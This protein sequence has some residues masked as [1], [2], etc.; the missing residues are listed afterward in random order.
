MRRWLLTIAGVLLALTVQAADISNPTQFMFVGDRDDDIID[1]ISLADAKLVHRIETSIHAD[2]IIATPFAPILM[3]AN[4]E[5]K[6]AVFYNLEE[7]AEVAKIDLPI[8][9]RHV[10][11]DTTGAKIGIS[12]SVDGGFVL[13]HAYKKAIEF[14]LPDFPATSDVLF[15]PNDVDIYFS[16]QSTGSIGLLDANTQRIYEMSLTEGEGDVLSSP[17]RSL[18]AR[19]VYVSNI[20]TGEVYSL[21]AYSRL[22]FNVFEIGGV[23]ARPYTTPQGAFLYMLEKE[24]GRFVSVEQRGFTEYAETTFD[25]GVDLVTVGRFDRMNLFLSSSN[26]QW[27]I[28]DNVEK[29]VVATGRFNGTPIDALGSADGKTA[30]VAFADTAEV[31]AVDLEDQTVTYIPATNNGGGAFT[32][33]LSNNV[34]H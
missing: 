25:H 28:F 34:C 29:K 21:N 27:S 18:D 17:S 20:T 10:V 15:D 13:L 32:V 8:A 11:L 6:Q 5:A 33:G 2:H 26:K 12:D 22:I 30:Y 31:A 7:K 3:Y 24:T 1:V 9:P 23:P 19:Y 14:A 4:T 16:N